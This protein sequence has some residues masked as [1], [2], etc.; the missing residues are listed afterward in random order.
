MS[1]ATSDIRS[2][3]NFSLRGGLRNRLSHQTKNAHNSLRRPSHSYDRKS[4]D[5]DNIGETSR[6]AD[7][8]ITEVKKLL[9]D[10]GSKDEAKD[11]KIAGG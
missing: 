5:L 4:S 6:D 2:M 3:G 10:S 7:E 9:E 11:D 1:D 8:S